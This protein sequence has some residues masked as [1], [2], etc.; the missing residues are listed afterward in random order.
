M[1]AMG[2]AA[3]L[4][5]EEVGARYK[6]TRERVRQVMKKAIGQISKGGVSVAGELSE[7]I[8]KGCIAAV[9]PL[10]PELLAEWLGAEQ[11]PRAVTRFLSTF[12]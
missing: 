8:A 7:G 10:T 9:H 3:P 5:L 6:V 1:G 12:A 4:T 2:T 11:S